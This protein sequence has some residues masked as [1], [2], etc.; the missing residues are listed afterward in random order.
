MGFGATGLGEVDGDDACRRG[1]PAASGTA[2]GDGVGVEAAMAGRRWGRQ[3]RGPDPVGEVE[4]TRKKRSGGAAEDGE[5]EVEG[6][7]GGSGDVV[8]GGGIGVDSPIQSGR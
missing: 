5:V 3:G 4:E 2:S 1:S 7:G 6:S 8:Q